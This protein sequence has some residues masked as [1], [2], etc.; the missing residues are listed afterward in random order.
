MLGREPGRDHADHHDV[1][2]PDVCDD[3]LLMFRGGVSGNTWFQTYLEVFS[4][5]LGVVR[6]LTMSRTDVRDLVA[7]FIG[8]LGL[9]V[10]SRYLCKVATGQHG[11][12]RRRGRF[13]VPGRQRPITSLDGE[14]DVSP[15]E[16]LAAADPGAVPVRR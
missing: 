9:W 1:L 5:V 14:I 3:K 12:G 6:L 16:E 4:L 11:L 15:R 7:V 2:P 8:S 13:S 10:C